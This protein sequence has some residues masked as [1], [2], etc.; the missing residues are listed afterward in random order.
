MMSDSSSS[1]ADS[2]DASSS[3]APNS[4]LEKAEST[5]AGASIA[6]SQV[7]AFGAFAGIADQGAPQLSVRAL[8][9]ESTSRAK[10]R[11]A[12]DP[13]ACPAS[14][15]IQYDYQYNT[16]TA[17]VTITYDKCDY[18]NGETIDGTLAVLGLDLVNTNYNATIQFQNFTITAPGEGTFTYNLDI[19]I[20]VNNDVYTMLL[21]GTMTY[22][23]TDVSGS[24]TYSNLEI[25]QD[26]NANTVTINGGLAF[27][28]T[29]DS[30]GEGTYNITTT[31]P[32]VYNMMT[33]Y[34]T[35]G[36]MVIDGVT[37]EFN[38]NETVTIT[39]ANGSVTK[40]QSELTTEC[41]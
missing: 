17:D 25:V 16:T 18:G 39:D 4:S 10:S 36:T 3:A 11:I 19:A 27:D 8:I 40:H 13:V 20:A 29:P 6:L 23:G 35:D 22:D 15:T 30:C 14:G 26:Y 9:T 1:A 7:Y 33:G 24:Y 28:T 38:S 5:Y 21:D 2:S 34:Y 31:E 12:L 32:L 37:Y 41:A